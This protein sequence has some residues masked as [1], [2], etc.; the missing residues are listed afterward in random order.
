MSVDTATA[1]RRCLPPASDAT[2]KPYFYNIETGKTSW[3]LPKQFRTADECPLFS[4]GDECYVNQ[5]DLLAVDEVA[6]IVT[7]S[8]RVAAKGAVASL[9][10]LLVTS[11]VKTI[12]EA[13]TLPSLWKAC[14]HAKK[15]L[16]GK[17][18]P[19]VPSV[20]YGLHPAFCRGRN[21]PGLGDFDSLK[22]WR[23]TAV[24]SVGRSSR[25]GRSDSGAAGSSRHPSSSFDGDSP[26]SLSPFH[27]DGGVFALEREVSSGEQDAETY[28]ENQLTGETSWKQPGEGYLDLSKE[29]NVW[30]ALESC[31][32]SIS[33]SLDVVLAKAGVWPFCNE[34]PGSGDASSLTLLPELFSKTV[35]AEK[36]PF[37]DATAL[38]I[39]ISRLF[40]FAKGLTTLSR[41][42]HA[43]DEDL[44]R[45][46]TTIERLVSAAALTSP[47]ETSAHH[48]IKEL[49][50]GSEKLRQ[51]ADVLLEGLA[52][53]T[54]PLLVRLLCEVPFLPP[55]TALVACEALLLLHRR[56][57]GNDGGEGKNPAFT[58]EA[59]P[60][61][62][63]LLVATA[64]TG[65]RNELAGPHVWLR[66]HKKLLL[67][68]PPKIETA[69]EAE[70]Q[71]LTLI[72]THGD[73]AF[74]AAFSSPDVQRQRL[75]NA[76]RWLV[77]LT[78]S[79]LLQTND[80]SASSGLLL[81]ELMLIDI[82]N[83]LLAVL[84]YSEFAEAEEE[85]TKA[86]KGSSTSS[87]RM[88]LNALSVPCLSALVCLHGIAERVAEVSSGQETVV[89]L[90]LR[91]WLETL[92]KEDEEGEADDSSS[93]GR[94]GGHLVAGAFSSGMASIVNNASGG[95][96]GHAAVDITTGL[97]RSFAVSLCIA[98]LSP[99]WSS[100]SMF[101]SSDLE[102]LVRVSLQELEDLPPGDLARLQFISLA[103]VA[104]LTSIKAAGGGKVAI[105]SNTA[106]LLEM[107]LECLEA[108]VAA[109][110][111]NTFSPSSGSRRLSS[112]SSAAKRDTRFHLPSIVV[113]EAK[114]AL[115]ELKEAAVTTE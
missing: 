109:G 18:A 14:D 100:S 86:S 24:C 84:N 104:L 106:V 44:S 59:A 73:A 78:N 54:K 3:K 112:S 27:E 77:V 19:S 12:E 10:S 21:L 33:A 87:L 91:N 82:T 42:D 92:G 60:V 9:S 40:S 5:A 46:S 22:A 94:G 35:E 16:L 30:F 65:I 68:S 57:A 23:R 108:L 28:Y 81:T 70:A 98:L 105:G 41:S 29:C 56:D 85:A 95:S 34:S 1:W 52:A 36:A 102:V 62:L 66:G 15:A 53:V 25:T 26:A 97:V 38:H 11:S 13:G 39:S 20:H 80:A 113:K 55:Q 114:A 110:L 47:S 111:T 76:R 32:T 17:K 67:E 49:S 103:K 75:D 43:G 61:S 74:K 6:K 31:S 58:P 89:S 90:C 71:A 48:P 69:N 72:K 79:L 83:A 4:S 88:V 2:A 63:L 37:V 93:R 64:I 101:F 99:D 7:G 107:A 51:S 96:S 115:D 8:Q 45:I 50:S